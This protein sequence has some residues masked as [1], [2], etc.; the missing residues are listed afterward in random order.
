MVS[1]LSYSILIIL[2]AGFVVDRWLDYL[3]EANLSLSLPNELL[4]IY[5][6]EK[7]QISV[8]YEKVTY[9]F[10]MLTESISFI[11]ILLFFVAGGF[12]WLDTIIRTRVNNPIFIALLFFAI[13]GLVSQIAS[14]PFS[15]Y[16]TFV[17]EEKF[18][19]NKTTKRLFILDQIKGLMVS[20]LAG[21]VILTLIV[22]IY[23]I[24]GHLFWLYALLV[25]AFFSVFMLLFYSSIIV[26]LFNKQTPLPDGIL[27]NAIT[28]FSIAAGF[29]L[30]NIY[31]IDGSKRSTKANAYFTG[32]GRKKRIVLF[33]TLINDLNT[34]EIVAVL[35]HEIGHNKKHHV[36]YGLFFSLVTTAIM[37]YVFS[38]V[39]AYPA[40]AEVLGSKTPSFHLSVI[41]FGMLYSPLSLIIG[42][43]MNYISRINEYQADR[44]AA[45]K[46]NGEHLAS[47][48]KKLSVNNLNNLTPHPAY[49]F[50][51]YSHPTLLQ[52]LKKL[53]ALNKTNSTVF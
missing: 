20:A 44:F 14:L 36:Y 51:H 21:G 17:I 49:V 15:W 2:I 13:L 22:W 38:L 1:F 34:E 5:D 43:G 32:L 40:F 35:A 46:Y 27:K 24:A 48:L 45:E 47:A 10:T 31:V 29:L 30:D 26:P 52:R 19:F 37:L 28:Q 41:S 53:D 18:G 16:S 33:D 8:K 42:L 39:S 7:Y 4:G 12:G 50:F 11:T 25:I 9:R 23:L 6:E 3:N